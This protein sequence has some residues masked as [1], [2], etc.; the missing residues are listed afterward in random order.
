MLAEDPTLGAEARRLARAASWIGV[1][2][3]LVPPPTL[4]E[5]V[6]V[7]V[8]N[9]AT[10]D[11]VLAAYQD[12]SETFASVV[13]ALPTD[14]LDTPTVNGLRAHELVVHMAAQ[15]S[16]LAA[17]AGVPVLPELTAI[18]IDARTAAL[19]AL[20]RERPLD[21]ATARW[22]DAVDAN[23]VWARARPGA[24]VE[25]RGMPMTRDDVLVVHAFE[26]WIHTDDLRRA[27]GRPLE[28]PTSAQLAVMSEFASRVLPVSLALSG[29]PHPGHCVRLVLTGD[30]G[31][32]WLVALDGD[33]PG[34][35]DVVL[36]ADVVDWCRRVGDRIPA[37]ELR[38][39]VRGDRR[40]GDDL[41]AAASALATL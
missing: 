13:A 26:T 9:S 34:D 27:Q 36:T 31:G 22:R 33:A 14:E 20:L 29:T 38:C 37:A 23:T 6:F 32:E 17:A 41:V 18:D 2:E 35:P 8:Q 28:P 11:P 21:D 39:R 15:A 16:L 25:W 1:T 30:G 19:L 7:A 24:T 5:R 3:A 4:R 40:L 12:L 10:V